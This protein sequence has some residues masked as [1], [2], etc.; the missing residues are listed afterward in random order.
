[1]K[2][3]LEEVEAKLLENRVEPNKVQ[4]ILRQLTE[5]VEEVQAEREAEAGP[6][7]KWEHV[8]V[9][10]DPNNILN[11]QEIAGWV[12][13]QEADADA[14][15]IFGKLRETVATQNETAKRKKNYITDLTSAFEYLKPKFLKE[16][17][18][19]IKTKELTRV[20]VTN[21]QL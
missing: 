13:Q 5:V 20:L 9:L 12:V 1:M 3:S 19:R 8:I 17:K 4:T 11:G 7:Q 14:A 18:L 21:G 10:N 6:K 16:K 2:V 15:L